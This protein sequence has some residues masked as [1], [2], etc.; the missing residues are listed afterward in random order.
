M[1][2]RMLVRCPTLTRASSWRV[3]GQGERSRSR[4]GALPHSILLSRV[5]G[6]DEWRGCRR[7][8]QGGRAEAAGG[9]GEVEADA[10]EGEEEGRGGCP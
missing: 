10:R 1:L 6:A 4:L 3:Q 7:E 2:M 5:S 9:G 8:E